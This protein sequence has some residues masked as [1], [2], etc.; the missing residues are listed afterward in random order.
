MANQLMLTLK[1]FAVE[2]NKAVITTIHQPSSRLFNMFDKI[3]L[4]ADG[5]VSNKKVFAKCSGLEV[6]M[7]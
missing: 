5:Q 6:K 7:L 4:L 2:N 3:L 1:K